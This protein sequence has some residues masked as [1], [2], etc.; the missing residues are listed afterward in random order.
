MSPPQ[1]HGFPIWRLLK[2]SFHLIQ[3]KLSWAP[4]N[5]AHIN[6]WFD[7]IINLEPMEHQAPLHPLKER[8]YSKGL[9]LLKHFSI[10]APNGDWINLKTS[11][12][13]DHLLPLSSLLFNRLVGCAPIKSSNQTFIVRH[14]PSTQLKQVILLQS[15]F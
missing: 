1:L 7:R 8:C 11:Y 3:S 14:P 15:S 12:T 10:W 13:L 9:F 2:H 6:V 4:G 5:G